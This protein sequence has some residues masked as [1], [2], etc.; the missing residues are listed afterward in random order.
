MSAIMNISSNAS[1]ALSGKGIELSFS[2]ISSTVPFTLIRLTIVELSTP[3]L[4]H[5]EIKS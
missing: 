4:S 5:R 1:L 2:L 3:S